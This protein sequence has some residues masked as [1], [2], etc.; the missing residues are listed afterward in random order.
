MLKCIKINHLQLKVVFKLL[1]TSTRFKY[2]NL[3]VILIINYLINSYHFNINNCINEIWNGMFYE[4]LI[5]GF[6]VL[7]LLIRRYVQF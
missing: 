7:L 6:E 1:E 4:I 3:D 5:I 2:Y